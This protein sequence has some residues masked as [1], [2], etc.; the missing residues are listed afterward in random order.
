MTSVPLR[1][2]TIERVTLNVWVWRWCASKSKRSC[3]SLAHVLETTWTPPTAAA[4]GARAISRL[5]WGLPAR[6]KELGRW[7]C[8]LARTT[9]ELQR[10]CNVSA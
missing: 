5:V 4:V 1:R 8:A 9:R 6:L 10:A 7:G 2:N 3:E